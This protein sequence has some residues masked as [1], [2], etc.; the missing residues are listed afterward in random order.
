VKIYTKAEAQKEIERLV[1]QFDAELLGIKKTP[2]IKEAHIEDKYIKPLFRFLNWN[3]SNESLAIARHEFVVQASHQIGGS[4]LEPDYLLRLPDNATGRMRNWL[5]MEAKHPKYDLSSDIRWIRQTYLYAHSTLN[6]TDHPENRVRL[7]ALTD[8]EEFRLFDCMDPLPLT[9]NNVDLFNK[10]IVP[11]FDLKYLDYVSHFDLLWDTFERSNVLAG[12]LEALC[13][14]EANKQ[15]QRRA[16]DQRFLRDLE[17]WRLELAKSMFRNDSKLSDDMLTA[18]AQLIIDRIVFIKMLSDRHIESDYLSR[19]IA[20]IKETKGEKISLYDACRKVFSRLNK[21]YNGSIFERRAELDAVTIDNDVIRSILESLR[22][23]ITTYTFAAMP[24]EIIGYA[25]E[26]FL[27]NVLQRSGKTIE[28]V[29]K[30][31]GRKLKGVYYTPRYIV[32]YIVD[33]TL[34]R[35]LSK[36]S[37]PLDV[38]RLKVLDPACGSGSFLLVVY[39]RLLQW[40]RDFF[41]QQAVLL[42]KKDKRRKLLSAVEYASDVQIFRVSSGRFSVRLTAK[43]KKQILANNVYGVDLDAQAVEVTKFSLSMKALENVTRE[44]LDED[45]SLWKSTVL[46][47]LQDNIKCGNSLISM[48][49]GLELSESEWTN[50]KP[51]DWK[52]EFPL[53]HQDKNYPKFDVVVANPPY[54]FTREQLSAIERSYFENHY[55]A[56]EDKHNTF[57]L[58]MELMHRL[59]APT[60]LAGV[61]VPNS[62]LT[63]ESAALLRAL[64]IPHLRLIADL[65]Y[66]VFDEVSMEPCV[67]ITN[68]QKD[69]SPVEVLRAR[70]RQGLIDAVPDYIDRSQWTP[71]QYRIV[72]SGGELGDVI[73]RLLSRCQTVGDVFDVRT[74]MQAYERGRGTPEQTAADVKDHVFD[75]TEKDGDDCYPYLEGGDVERYSVRWSGSW[76]KYGPW[77]SQPRTIDIFQRPRVILREITGKPPYALFSAFTDQLM[78]SNKSVLTILHRQDDIE[79]LWLL[80]GLMNS[81]V[82]T[83]FYRERAV[84]S[85]RKL[86]PKVVINNLRE[87]PYPRNVTLA[88][89]SRMVSLAKSITELRRKGDESKTADQAQ[90]QTRRIAALNGEIDRYAYEIFGLSVDEQRLIELA[91]TE[92]V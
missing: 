75:R 26:S 44:E 29:P 19:L 4:T 41:E 78:L 55:S 18:A 80:L 81:R 72:L 66:F 13:V 68:G 85:I 48:D 43:L 87:F 22:P 32:E 27:G 35:A 89:K 88:L 40:Y 21:I 56:S 62:W 3:T 90:Q 34:G 86:F 6:K 37:S 53:I 57:L 36:C 5:F 47:D 16:P 51:F 8:F 25:Y 11:G 79:K 59:L 61:I 64:L 71:P 84:K 12:S 1:E 31:T 83:V 46:P 33:K 77:L 54:I 39:D 38:A 7:A 10:C 14:T 92:A 24:V 67:A 23:D 82:M 91:G 52:Q 2:H 63:I 50:L 65:N 60:G 58:F 9:Q 42:E 28:S 70:S 76:M 49:V 45:R 69:D 20:D 17:A 73:V 30:P 74:G 15:Q